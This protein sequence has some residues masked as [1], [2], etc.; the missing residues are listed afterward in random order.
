MTFVILHWPEIELEYLRNV[1]LVLHAKWYTKHVQ[2]SNHAQEYRRRKRVKP[3]YITF[4]TQTYTHTYMYIYIYVCVYV[5][6]PSIVY[7]E[8]FII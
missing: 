1:S 4:L 2:T 6:N 3:Y 5:C 7:Y 8:L